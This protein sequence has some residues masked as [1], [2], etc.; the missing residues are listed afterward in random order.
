MVEDTVFEG[1]QNTWG[2]HPEFC[3]GGAI[4]GYYMTIR[5]CLFVDNVAAADGGAVFLDASTIENCVFL[6]NAAPNGAAVVNSGDAAVRNCTL[7]SNR[8]TMPGGAALEMNGNPDAIRSHLIIA[9]TIGG[10]AVD[11]IDSGAYYCSDFWNN[12]GGDYVGWLCGILPSLGDFSQ[13]PLFCDPETGDLGLREGSPCLP[14]SHGSG[15]PCGLVG[16]HGLGCNLVPVLPMTWG[17]LK[18]LYR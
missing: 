3:Y 1:N 13:D 11:C 10:A 7:L 9:G 6:R 4:A 16:A 5:N 2:Y 17:R 8:V 18:A 14:G 15:V 12:D